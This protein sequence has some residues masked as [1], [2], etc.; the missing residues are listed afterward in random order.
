MLQSSNTSGNH[1]L[2]AMQNQSSGAGSCGA[3]AGDDA[4]GSSTLVWGVL[5]GIASNF[6]AAL[7]MTIQKKGHNIN[8]LRPAK[9][10]RSYI[11][12]AGFL[13][14]TLGSLINLGALAM[15]PQSVVAG[16]G[17]LVLVSNTFLAPLMLGE[18]VSFRHDIPATLMIIGATILM[19]LFGSQC[20][21]EYT[22]D[23]LVRAFKAPGHLV[24]FSCLWCIVVVV[25][26][27]IKVQERRHRTLRVVPLEEPLEDDG[28]SV[29][30]VHHHEDGDEPSNKRDSQ[31]E[32]V[33]PVNQVAL[34]MTKSVLGSEDEVAREPTKRAS[35]AVYVIS[36]DCYDMAHSKGMILAWA[37]ALVA[38]SCAAYC[39]VF[40]KII[41]ELVKTTILGTPQL[42]RPEFYLFIL[43]W[44]F[45]TA[46][47]INYMN[48]CLK[49]FPA[50]FIVPT[51]Q[52]GEGRMRRR[53]YNRRRS[54][55]VIMGMR[56]PVAVVRLPPQFLTMPDPPCTLLGHV[57]VFVHSLPLF[58][59]TVT[60]L[61]CTLLS[62]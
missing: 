2:L 57:S 39:I 15:A 42:H 32:F 40:S 26:V 43:A 28:A 17:T 48:Y 56:C 25:A 4:E 11:V 19:V 54:W 49:Y 55:G 35:K 45:C 33:S 5:I 47:Q 46:F 59:L 8:V 18:R 30:D 24:F 23:E 53:T 37:Y 27:S 61:P 34:P 14:Y 6:T 12:V 13:V 51:L 60:F 22:A 3:A 44:C 9:D 52:V 21:P 62:T 7:G 38:G 31:E 41:S 50:L 36:E 1:T 20:T 29:K 58:A 16:L 10:R